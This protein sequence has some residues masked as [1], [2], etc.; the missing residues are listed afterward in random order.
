MTPRCN[1]YEICG[2]C[3]MQH[4]D[5]ALQ[6]RQSSACWRTTSARIGRVVPEQVL[7]PIYAAPWAYRHRA[8]LSVHFVP[9]KGGVL[10]GFRER[11]R[12]MW[13]TCIPAVL[14]GGMGRLIDPLREVMS[15]LDTRTEF[16]KS[17]W[18]WVR[19]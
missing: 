9:K 16:R 14:A 2:G 7:P 6:W 10:V 11:N 15:T 19:R 8:R 13:R 18:L 4:M 17:K 12:A 1:F 5:P 3:A